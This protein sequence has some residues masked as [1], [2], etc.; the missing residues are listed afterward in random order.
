M[1]PTIG[2][3]GGELREEGISNGKAKNGKNRGNELE[4]RR[5]E[6][7]EMRKNRHRHRHRDRDRDGDRPYTVDRAGQR[8]RRPIQQQAVLVGTECV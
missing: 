3:R 8:R 2:Q 4:R 1:V 5:T 6:E 7:K